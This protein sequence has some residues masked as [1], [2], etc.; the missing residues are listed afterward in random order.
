[1]NIKRHCKSD[2][3][4]FAISRK[5]IDKGSSGCRGAR[6]NSLKT[7]F[8]QNPFERYF[9]IS[10]VQAH[11]TYFLQLARTCVC[12][13]A[14]GVSRKLFFS[15]FRLHIFR[16]VSSDPIGN[17]LFRHWIELSSPLTMKLNS[18][19]ENK[20]SLLSRRQ[21]SITIS[22]EPSKSIRAN[23]D[24]FFLTV[25]NMIE[26]QIPSSAQFAASL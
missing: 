13:W 16:S 3:R 10:F 6:E 4:S 8:N 15:S 17:K 9:M 21:F 11:K 2:E 7:T 18:N 22:L 1:M 25:I 20:V 12:V 5:F 14:W 23:F 24:F 19:D 26:H